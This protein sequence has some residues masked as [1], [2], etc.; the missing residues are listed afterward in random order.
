MLYEEIIHYRPHN[1]W[2]V[3]F[4]KYEILVCTMTSL[5]INLFSLLISL[6]TVVLNSRDQPENIW[7]SKIMHLDK[8]HY[9]NQNAKNLPERYNYSY[10]TM[11]FIQTSQMLQYSST[12]GF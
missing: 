4:K 7:L 8:Q 5:P 10:V 12:R 1:N 3:I 11:L 6:S 9:E 2:F